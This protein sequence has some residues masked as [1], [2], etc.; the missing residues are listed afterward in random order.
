MGGQGEGSIEQK[1]IDL[2]QPT[3][4]IVKFAG[5]VINLKWSA[6]SRARLVSIINDKDRINKI[7]AFH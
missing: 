5:S 6:E 2:L 1:Y 3:Y 7:R 4:N